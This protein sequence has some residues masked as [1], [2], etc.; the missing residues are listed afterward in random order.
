MSLAPLGAQ[1]H[2]GQGTASG[3]LHKRA[4]KPA[5]AHQIGLG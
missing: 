4:E 1:G 3:K 5:E 2:A